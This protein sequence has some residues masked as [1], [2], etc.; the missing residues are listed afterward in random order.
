MK[1]SISRKIFMIVSGMII[2]VILL[3]YVK[4]I[5]FNLSTIYIFFALI[6][7]NNL[8]GRNIYWII[9]LI[10]ILIIGTISTIIGH[11]RTNNLL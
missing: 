7:N 1:H 9:S 11:N 6:L 4:D 5:F 8:N 2:S 10:S 3:A